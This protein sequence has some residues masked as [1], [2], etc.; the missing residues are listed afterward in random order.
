MIAVKQKKL[1]YQIVFLSLWYT[2]TKYFTLK[3]L[4]KQ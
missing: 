3:T 4:K 2:L 1:A